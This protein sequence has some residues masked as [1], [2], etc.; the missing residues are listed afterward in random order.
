MPRVSTDR[1]PLCGLLIASIALATLSGCGSG[2]ARVK[3]TVTMDGETITKTDVRRCTVTLS[4]ATG[5]G[6]KASGSVDENGVFYLSTGAK[7]GVMPGEYRA[8]VKVRDVI[9][10]KQAGDYSSA[11]TLSPKK[12]A[13]PS[14]SGLTFTVK[15]GSNNYDIEISSN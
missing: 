12:Y 14:T 13:K 6:A 7:S 1:L 4:P 3:G 10:P 9:P 8:S 5:P 2:L 11:K 15:R